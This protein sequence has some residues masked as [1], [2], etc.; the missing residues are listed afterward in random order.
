MKLKLIRS[1]NVLLITFIALFTLF[2]TS[3][4]CREDPGKKPP[5]NTN[6]SQSILGKWRFKDITSVFMS[7]EVIRYF[8]KEMQDIFIYQKDEIKKSVK[9]ATFSFSKDGDYRIDDKNRKIEGGKYLLRHEGKSIQL[10]A[11]NNGENLIYEIVEV[12]SK[13]MRLLLEIPLDEEGFILPLE[14]IFEREGKAPE[15]P[16]SRRKPKD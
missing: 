11:D 8:P 7:E 15:E 5:F 13:R 6:P 2:S 1:K 10:T 4:G 12:N 16:S 9:D 3:F 14:F